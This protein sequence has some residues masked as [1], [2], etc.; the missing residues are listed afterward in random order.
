LA[1]C[2]YSSLADVAFVMY[3]TVDAMIINYH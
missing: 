2:I 3:L 1:Y